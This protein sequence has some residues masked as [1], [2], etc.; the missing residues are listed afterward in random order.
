MRQLPAQV[1][2]S[3]LLKVHSVSVVGV[4]SEGREAWTS[5]LTFTGKFTKNRKQMLYK[6]FFKK[7]KTNTL[8]GN[9][10]TKWNILKS[11]LLSF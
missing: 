6:E 4:E 10:Q 2:G 9:L 1:L 7:L 8:Q 11:Y 5:D 3:A